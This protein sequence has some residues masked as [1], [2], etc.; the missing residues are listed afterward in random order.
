VAGPNA[1]TILKT[2]RAIPALRKGTHHVD[3]PVTQA[4]INPAVTY[5]NA[6]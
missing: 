2:S 6:G 1:L 5:V 3:V 4:V